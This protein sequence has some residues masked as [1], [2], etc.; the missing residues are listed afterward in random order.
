M[1]NEQYLDALMLALRARMITGPEVGR[2]LSEVSNHLEDSGSNPIAEFGDPVAFAAQFAGSHRFPRSV[3][4]RIITYLTSAG[5]GIAAVNRTWVAS[6]TGTAPVTLAHGGAFL[7]AMVGFVAVSFLMLS[8]S[9][10]VLEG[11]SL[12]GSDRLVLAVALTALA[13]LP[14]ATYIWLPDKVLFSWPAGAWAAVLVPTVAHVAYEISRQLREG[15]VP[16]SRSVP[17]DVGRVIDRYKGVEA[18]KRSLQLTTE[19]ILK[20]KDR[21]ETD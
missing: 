16:L 7:V 19:A 11:R 9:A 5:I 17:L 15:P 14:P 4:F 1:T 21:N 13:G 10:E 18:F 12:R 6:Q 8:K 3:R 2:I 20:S